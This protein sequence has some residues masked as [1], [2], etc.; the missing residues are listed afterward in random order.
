[1]QGTKYRGFRK[2]QL[3]ETDELKIPTKPIV[4]QWTD[5]I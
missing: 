3:N 4:F 1:M 2:T 5:I